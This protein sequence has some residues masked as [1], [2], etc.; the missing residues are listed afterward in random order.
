MYVKKLHKDNFLEVKKSRKNIFNA[1]SPILDENEILK[2]NYQNVLKIS[3]NHD[4]VKFEELKKTQH[5][6]KIPSL[7]FK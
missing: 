1:L 5:L 7:N 6:K 4:F 3:V 2:T